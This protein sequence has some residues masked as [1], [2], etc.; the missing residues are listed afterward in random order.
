M[1]A[2]FRIVF[3]HGYTSSH[4]ADWYPELSTLMDRVGWDYVIPDLPGGK[5]PH[6]AEWLSKLHAVIT[7]DDRPLILVGHSLGTRAALLYL[8]KYRPQVNKVFLIGAFANWVENAERR[9]GEA[10]P[11]FFTHI[12]DL[13]QIKPLVGEFVVIHSEDDDSI[14]FVQGQTI[15]RELGAELI[16]LKD[17]G[18]VTEPA[19]API[20][21]EILQQK[22]A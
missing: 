21:F 15:A 2:P 4:K 19:D 10:Y 1:A 14:P 6:A 3:I 5:H 8:E 11:D 7:A 13:E 22:I 18:H 17:R 9:D 12:I 20:I 16:T